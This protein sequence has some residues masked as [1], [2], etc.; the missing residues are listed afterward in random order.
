MS[1]SYKKQ[2]SRRYED[3]YNPLAYK[4]E[5]RQHRKEKKLKNC[6]RSNNIDDLMYDEDDY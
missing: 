5:L 6:L 4:N 3:D 1:K 2:S